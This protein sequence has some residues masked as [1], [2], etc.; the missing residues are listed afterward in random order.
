MSSVPYHLARRIDARRALVFLG[1]CVAGLALLGLIQAKVWS[2][3]FQAFDLGDSD[4]DARLSMPAT[5]TSLL[6]ASSALLSLSLGEVDK[7]TRERR[8]RRAGWVFAALALEELLGIHNWLDDRGV[9][10][11]ATYLP[12]LLVAAL[13]W[14]DAYRVLERQPRTQ[15]LFGAAVLAWLIGG[16]LD[17]TSNA[18]GAEIFEMAGAA[19]FVVSLLSRCQYLARAYHP[20]DEVETRPS[21]DEIAGAV[22]R[23]IEFRRVAIVLGLVTAAF[24]LQYVILHTGNYRHSE[25]A[26][27][28]DLNNEQTLWATFQGSLIWVVGGIAVLIACLESTRAATRRWWLTLGLVLLVL[29]ADEVIAFHDRFQEAVVHPG[30]IVL[31]PLAI[32]GVIAWWKALREISADRVARALFITGAIFWF[33]SQASDVFLNPIESLRWTITPEELGETIGS[34]F[35]MFALLTWLRARLEAPAPVDVEAL[36][37]LASANGNLVELQ[38]LSPSGRS[39]DQAPTG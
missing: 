29:G 6:L 25:R 26:P 14:F 27:I 31:A 3:Y 30:Q 34:A 38:P 12:L 5:F 8:W 33:L 36:E 17:V 37:D 20:I 2:W 13:F 35:W 9:S 28:L 24:A 39:G 32:L 15:A 22:I 23:R 10:S 16:V 18:G 11:A 1:A 7:R 19:L 21:I 4:L